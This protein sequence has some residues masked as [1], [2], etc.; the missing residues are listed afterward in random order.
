MRFAK[1]QLIIIVLN[2]SKPFVEVGS[3]TVTLQAASANISVGEGQCQCQ[4]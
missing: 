1:W 4:C 3:Q 2:E